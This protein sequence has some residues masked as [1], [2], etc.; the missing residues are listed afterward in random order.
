M[1]SKKERIESAE[2]Q[3]KLNVD[4]HMP[5]MVRRL[6]KK[7]KRLKILLGGYQSRSLAIDKQ[8]SELADQIDQTEMTLA[9]A[10]GQ[11]YREQLAMNARLQVN[12]RSSL[13]RVVQ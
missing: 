12:F 13:S 8:I 4:E 10:R 6:A 9:G 1:A 3:L 5:R 2:R 7:E 11:Q